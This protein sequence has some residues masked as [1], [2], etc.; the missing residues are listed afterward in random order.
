LSVLD[1]HLTASVPYL[2]QFRLSSTL[3]AQG[4]FYVEAG[5]SRSSPQLVLL[6]YPTLPSTPDGNLGKVF[7]VEQENVVGFFLLLSS[8][9]VSLI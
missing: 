2:E 3:K 9:E 1:E 5:I 4:G 6:A 7:R 8:L